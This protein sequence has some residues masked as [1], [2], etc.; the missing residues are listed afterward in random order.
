MPRSLPTFVPMP[1][2]TQHRT[3]KSSRPR[4]CMRFGSMNDRA[5]CAG[6]GSEAKAAVGFPDADRRSCDGWATR[7]RE[8]FVADCRPALV[9]FRDFG[10]I[11]H[12]GAKITG[13][14][15]IDAR[16][17]GQSISG[18]SHLKGALSRASKAALLARLSARTHPPYQNTAAEIAV[19]EVLIA[20]ERPGGPSL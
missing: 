9:P 18:N 3:P 10:R 20:S 14:R 17:F 4:P 16:S 11:A 2:S 13:D 6:S 19:P 15:L 8:C 5:P 7:H 12:R 1:T